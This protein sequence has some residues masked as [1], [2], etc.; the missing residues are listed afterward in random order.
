MIFNKEDKIYHDANNTCHI[1][2]IKCINKVRD[3][4]HE[5][6]KYRG[7]AYN[8]CNL[9]YRQ[10]NLIPVIFKHGKAYDLNLL[11]DEI[12]EPKW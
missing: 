2:G 3:H 7:P 8:I 1:C 9:T 12:F 10:Q 4:C 5:T 11:F 6:G